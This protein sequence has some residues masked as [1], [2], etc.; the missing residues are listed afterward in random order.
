LFFV[1]LIIK[2]DPTQRVHVPS[3]VRHVPPVD[4]L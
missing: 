1:V 3:A 4:S 2:L